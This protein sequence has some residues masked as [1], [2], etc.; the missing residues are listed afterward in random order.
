MEKGWFCLKF[1]EIKFAIIK[2]VK[3]FNVTV[4]LVL[5]ISFVS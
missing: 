2:L 5:F 4:L 1:G 3:R